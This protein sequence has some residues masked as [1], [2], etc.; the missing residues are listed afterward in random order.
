MN[1]Q[2]ITPVLHF[3]VKT[4]GIIFFNFNPPEEPVEDK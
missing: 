1:A 4:S 3:Q 2:G